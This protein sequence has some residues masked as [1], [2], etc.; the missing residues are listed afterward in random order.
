VLLLFWAAVR[1]RLVSQALVLERLHRCYSLLR[2]R[3]A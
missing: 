3:W 1:S 2:A